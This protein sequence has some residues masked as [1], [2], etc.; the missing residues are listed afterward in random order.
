MHALTES[1]HEL[2]TQSS[3]QLVMTKMDRVAIKDLVADNR[4]NFATFFVNH[5]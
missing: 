1:T 4:S 5:S 2:A 3:A